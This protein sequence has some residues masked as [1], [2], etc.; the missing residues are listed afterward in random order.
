MSPLFTST[1]GV[2]SCGGTEGQ[3]PMNVGGQMEWVDPAAPPGAPAGEAFPVGSV[4]L[5]VVATNPATLLGY[6]TWVAIA[7]GRML[8]GFNAGDPDFDTDE[9]V[10]GAKTH[11][12]AT[13]NLPAHNHPVVDPGHTHLTTRYPTATGALTGFTIDTS[14]S[15]T[16]VNNTLATASATT[17]VTTSNTGS[18]TAVNHMPP[19]LVLRIWKRA[20]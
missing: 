9:E 5:S 8:V 6:G 14:M 12:L 3:V 15:G 18:G 2:L 1:G 7:A 19:F 4:F 13:A 20:A 17:G 10:G 11:T 16:P